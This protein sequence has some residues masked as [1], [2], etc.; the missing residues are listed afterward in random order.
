V[1]YALVV[2]GVAV[3]AWYVTR[4]PINSAADESDL[5]GMIG[6]EGRALETF[7][8]SGRVFVRGEEW[9]ASAVRGIIEN[10]MS[11]RVVAYQPGMVLL[12]EALRKE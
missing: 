12:V 1:F 4:W 3:A 8:D 5:A 9:K 2:C 10:G 7:S 6:Q 11:V